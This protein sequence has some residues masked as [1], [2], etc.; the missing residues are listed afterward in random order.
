MADYD[1]PDLFTD[2]DD[3]WDIIL[4]DPET[5]STDPWWP[6]IL[7]C[8]VTVVAGAVAVLALLDRGPF[9]P[10]GVEQLGDGCEIVERFPAEDAIYEHVVCY[11]DWNGRRIRIDD[12]W[13]YAE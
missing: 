9:A 8:L 10:D 7:V 13:R 2:E 12:Q 5:T 3:A 4:E 6:R 11:A 1:N